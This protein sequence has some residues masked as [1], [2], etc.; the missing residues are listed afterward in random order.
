MQGN[1]HTSAPARARREEI[2]LYSSRY[3]HLHLWKQKRVESE[4]EEEGKREIRKGKLG[5]FEWAT[6]DTGTEQP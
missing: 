4:K 1:I 3:D 6:R 2:M 5:G